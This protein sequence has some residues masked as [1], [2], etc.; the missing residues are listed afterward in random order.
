MVGARLAILLVTANF[1]TSKFILGREVPE[2]LRRRKD[3]G[4]WIVP[5]IAKPCAWLRVKWLAEM[6]VRPKNGMA[7]WRDGGTHVDEELAR[8]AD[9]VMGVLDRVS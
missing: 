2:L 7:V 3:E 5:V 4:L 6:N 1:L 9:E 8:I